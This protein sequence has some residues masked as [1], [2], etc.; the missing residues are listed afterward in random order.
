MTKRNKKKTKGQGKSSRFSAR[1]SLIAIGV[2][3]RRWQLFSV[4]KEKVSI[5][6]KVIKHTSIEKLTDAFVLSTDLLDNSVK[7]DVAQPPTTNP[8]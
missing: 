5:A 4:I 7:F 6:P 1:A 2:F 8:F 3:A